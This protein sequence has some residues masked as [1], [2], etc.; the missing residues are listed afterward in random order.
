MAFKFQNTSIILLFNEKKTVT[1]LLT[2][3]YIYY[4]IIH[5]IDLIFKTISL[6]DAFWSAAM[7]T[8]TRNVLNRS[9]INYYVFFCLSFNFHYPLWKLH[10]VRTLGLQ[11]VKT[12]SR[13]LFISCYLNV[14]QVKINGVFKR[15]SLNR[16][17]HMQARCWNVTTKEI[18][19][20]GTLKSSLLS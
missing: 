3:V 9:N 4:E 15:L 7:V 11:S 1:I 8:L 19:I 20:I 13:S 10:T 17:L 14:L 5:D 2:Y 12:R 16:Q 6:F 18:I